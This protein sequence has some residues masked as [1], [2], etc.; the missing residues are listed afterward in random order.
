MY[1]KIKPRGSSHHGSEVMNLTSIQEDVGSI[2]GLTQWVNDPVFLWAVVLITD[3][4]QIPV[5]LWLWC[6]PA[7]TALSWPLTWEFP[8]AMGVALKRH[9]KKNYG[10]PKLA[11]RDKLGGWE[12]THYCIQNT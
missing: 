11:G 6:K 3:E 5:L 4:A 7:A 12:Y 10:Y 1:F 8:Y 2:P 9:L